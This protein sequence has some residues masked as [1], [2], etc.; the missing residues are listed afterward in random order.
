MVRLP[1]EISTLNSINDIQIEA[2]LRPYLGMSMIG[3]SCPRYLWYYL[4]WVFTPQLSGRLDRLF[5]RGRKEEQVV[6][7]TLE[8][9]GIKVLAIQES[10]IGSYGHVKGHSDGR[11]IGVLE[12][13]KTEHLL[14][15]KTHN[16]K[17]FKQLVKKGVLETKPMHYAQM[18]R[19]MK[20]LGLTRAL[21]YAVNK[22][23]DVLYIER[24]SFDSDYANLLVDKERAIVESTQVPPKIGDSTW[25]ECKFCD[26]YLV[27]HFNG[28]VNKNCRTCKDG[29]LTDGG[30]WHCDNQEREEFYPVLLTEEQQAMG[31]FKYK[32]LEEL[33]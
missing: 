10:I 26:A 18:Q 27:C 4:H 13:P 3:H 16:D 14:E 25:Y 32:V 23:D 12:A 9:V 21:Y 7:E 6:Y 8:K 22:N 19:Y 33:K 1:D 5:E 31:C 24:V 17:S 28:T 11:I 2:P 20:G 29:V 15:I 30:A